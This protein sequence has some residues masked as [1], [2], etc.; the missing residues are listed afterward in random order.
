MATKRTRAKRN[1]T[2]VVKSKSKGPV[3]KREL[4]KQLRM[5]R[6][7]TTLSGNIYY[8]GDEL[9]QILSPVLDTME[10]MTND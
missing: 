2:K 7:M 10:R 8:S 5:L 9:R 4:N 1:L 3:T 6:I